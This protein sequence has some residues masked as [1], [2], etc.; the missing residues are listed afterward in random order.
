M[1]VLYL[2]RNLPLFFL[3]SPP[4][5]VKEGERIVAKQTTAKHHSSPST[6]GNILKNIY[7]LVII[8]REYQVE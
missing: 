6:I 1:E 7:L 8:Y 5:S 4:L 2:A 3:K